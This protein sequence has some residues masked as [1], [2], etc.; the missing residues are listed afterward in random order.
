MKTRLLKITTAFWLITCTIM[1]VHGQN[2]T[3]A[4]KADTWVTYL[5]TNTGTNSLIDNRI[6]AILKS[7]DNKYYYGTDE[8]LSIKDGDLWTTL[9]R[10]DG[11]GR[12]TISALLE[13]ADGTIW[14]GTEYGGISKLSGG[15]ITTYTTSQGLANNSVKSIIEAADNTIWVGTI[16]GV[17]FFDGTSW[18]SSLSGLPSSSGYDLAFDSGD[19]LWISGANG[20]SKYDGTTITTFT[21]TEGLPNNYT[22]SLAID[23]SD[24]IWIGTGWSGLV[25][26][27]GS[28]FTTYTE[29][30]NLVDDGIKDLAFD[31]AGNLWIATFNGVGKYNGT[32]FTNYSSTDGL[33]NNSTNTLLIESATSIVFGT[34]YGIS[35]FNGGVWSTINTADGLVSNYLLAVHGNQNG[36]IAFGTYQ[37]GTSVFNGTTWESAGTQNNKLPGNW[38]NSVYVAS[39]NDV[40]IGTSSSGIVK[41][42]GTN[43][44]N[45]TTTDGFPDNDINYI[46]GDDAGNIWIATSG[47]G[48]A[49][50]D[51]STFTVYKQTD[52]LASNTPT[53][54]A[55]NGNEVW[56][57]GGG[58]TK[59]V[60]ETFMIY[61]TTDGLPTDYIES[62]AFANDLVYFGS[63]SGLTSFDGTNFVTK[64][65]TDGL[66]STSVEALGVDANGYLWIGTSSGAS[67]LNGN[68]FENYTIDNSSLVGNSIKSIYGD[69]N[70]NVWFAT[71]TGCSVLEQDLVVTATLPT[72]TTTAISAIAQTTATSGGNVISD[73]GAEVTARG[74]CWNTTANPTI[75]NSITSDG[76]GTGEYTSSLSGLTANTTYYV[77]AYATNSEGTAYG[78]EINFTTLQEV[79]TQ[80]YASLPVNESFDGTWI[81]KDDTRDVPSIYWKNTPATGNNSWRRFDD[82]TASGAWNFDSG[83]YSPTG[84][85]STNYSARFHTYNANAG[86][87]G[88]LELFIDFSTQVGEKELS[89]YYI[90]PSGTD[91]L[92][93]SV[94][95]DGGATYETQLIDLAV[96]ETWTKQ[97][98]N[99]GNLTSPQGAIK[100]EATSDWAADD[101][102]LDEISI[103]NGATP[104]VAAFSADITTGSA[105]LIVQF[106]DASS[107]NPTSWSWDF[108]ND[109]TEDATT[110]NPSFT[111]TS[112]GTYSVKLTVTNADG[113]DVELKTDY[114]VVNESAGCLNPDNYTMNFETDEDL[115]VWSYLDGNADGDFWGI[116]SDKG[117][118]GTACAIY[119]YNDVNAANDWLFTPCFDMEAEKKYRI[120]FSYAVAGSTFPEKLALGFGSTADESM[121]LVL[122]LG[123]ITNTDYTSASYDV[124]IESS[125]SYHF[126]WKCY[127]DANMWNVYLDG[128]SISVVTKSDFAGGSGTEADPWQIATVE[129]LVNVK[130]YLGNTHNDKYF[131]QIADIDLNVSPWNAGE[132]WEPIGS[133]Y[134]NY[135]HGHYNGDGFTISELY[136]NRPGVDN[137]GL[138][139]MIENAE[140]KNMVITG[141]QIAGNSYIGA[142]VGWSSGANITN[143]QINAV[144]TASGDYMAN[145]GGLA[146]YN[147]QTTITNCS[148]EATVSGAYYVGAL[149]GNNNESTYTHC[150]SAGTVN[151]TT[152]EGGGLIGRNYT[153]SVIDQCYSTADVSGKQKLGGFIGGNA[154]SDI[155]NSYATGMVTSSN[156]VSSF[157]GFVGY[158]DNTSV[159]ENCYS[160]GEVNSSTY[161]SG[162][163]AGTNF[164]TITNCFWNTQ[165]SGKTESNGGTGLTTAEML[166]NTLFASWNFTTIWD[167]LSNETY[168]FLRFQN[169]AKPH[170]YPEADGLSANFTADVTEGIAPLTVVFTDLSTG[171]P[172]AWAWDFDNDGTYD[173]YQQNPT[174]T[175]TSPGTFSVK[176]K[177]ATSTEENGITFTDYISVNP[178][179][180]NDVVNNAVFT[181][182]PNPNNGMAYLKLAD[183]TG[184]LNIE[185]I[186][187]AGKTVFLQSENY[188]A[189]A[190]IPIDLKAANTGIYFIKVSTDRGVS[191]KKLILE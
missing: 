132:G 23:A 29:S 146:G 14:I 8:G 88:I 47:G 24:N 162:G 167:Q 6:N 109:G 82:G 116:S 173:S 123:Q 115:S 68:A 48:V 10:D 22:T 150:F 26:Y 156:G 35:T 102:G 136:A 12:N 131:I 114:I 178:V 187:L 151:C 183:Y 67:R 83:A 159:I 18:F 134:G 149:V 86:T 91:W 66:P 181:V 106:T 93:V 133:G 145:V 36:M 78:N 31:A 184:V 141:A 64:T 61:T 54:I 4:T 19:N 77:R 58:V 129:H 59:M 34:E 63:S 3:K 80:E 147:F 154:S 28:T 37:F 161:A 60:G 110:Q 40:W 163:F 104:P 90:N 112:V 49:K 105:P 103:S 96:S 50:Y 56:I 189:E 97:S 101:I 43:Y 158:N 174:Y 138:F 188:F 70:A 177:V 190:V 153:N 87:K 25:K 180:I 137:Q 65:Y 128:I 122:D 135:F 140:I 69:K 165:T 127:S 57:A 186:D 119:S 16:S 170:N 84:A 100:F 73:G 2:N 44:T 124:T 117:I 172:T 98:I 157:G 85:N 52:G 27:D 9:T 71:T 118:D 30:D 42:D 11:L 72:V 155:S 144:V 120:S 168:P 32:T 94:S 39:N 55:I 21:T 121:D 17:S 5:T 75:A 81:D 89:F 179:G 171:K 182:Y 20:L 13:A 126:G 51:G 74:I 46:T 76:T 142:L 139:G 125:G 79:S 148:A 111:Y 113:S 164:A 160:I 175:Y 53:Y 45:I 130:K 62:I 185:V 15:V 7:S 143:C 152:E 1:M 38:I 108:N 99:L 95:A 41:Y 176:L 92:R 33:A 169:G 107:G 166:T 191:M